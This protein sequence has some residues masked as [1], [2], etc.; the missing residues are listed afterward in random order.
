M[1]NKSKSSSD[2]ND[3]MSTFIDAGGTLIMVLLKAVFD[4]LVF[5]FNRYVFKERQ[6]AEIKKIERK[7]LDCKKIASNK[8]EFGYSVTQRRPLS[9]DELDKKA[10]TA[11]IG[12]SGS[13]KTVLLDV[14]M[15]D[16]MHRNKPIIYV[17]PKGDNCTMNDFINMCRDANREFLIFNEYYNG[18]G[19]CKLNPIKEGSI[20]H[21]V[22]RISSAFT[23]SEEHYKNLCYEA[24]RDA[25]T[26]LKEKN[27]LITFSNIYN[28][29]NQLT[30]DK[31]NK[32]VGYKKKDIQGILTRIKNITD[33]DFGPKLEGANAYSFEEIRKTNK[34]VYIGL[35]VLGYA[36][37]AKAL[38][39]IFLGDLSHSIYEIYKVS[40]NQTLSKQ[41]PTGIYI[42]ELSAVIT[43]QFVEI[44]NKCRKA[45]VELNFAFQTPSD[46]LRVDQYFCDQILDSSSN[47]FIFKQRMEDGANL[48]SMSLGTKEGKKLTKRVDEG[49]EQNMGSLREVE[50]NIAHSNIIKNL[51]VG[52]AVLL[53]QYPTRIDL[54]NIKYIDPDILEENVKKLE[55]WGYINQL[56]NPVAIQ[57]HASSDLLN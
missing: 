30:D 26:E 34:C 6:S 44:L 50:E 52:Q 11:I 28:M 15:Y 54:V 37:T 57:K 4:G 31:S 9:T 12:A 16:D 19:A 45:K 8:S 49:Q 55:M 42:D 29:L 46:L 2:N 5:L 40:T 33:S 24:L 23:W 32:D 38:G 56:K 20:N 25:V 7:D 43:G 21:I 48:F 41:V 14:L 36:E 13:G 51:K 1:S 47:W 17:D 22:D 3:F 39:K 35:S 53:R 18:A 10:H 27:Q